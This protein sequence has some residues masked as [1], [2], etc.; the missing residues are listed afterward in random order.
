[1]TREDL[2][3]TLGDMGPAIVSD[4]VVLDTPCVCGPLL[5]LS[6]EEQM[7][8]RH[9]QASH[10]VLGDCSDAIRSHP[11]DKTVR[12]LPPF[13]DCHNETWLGPVDTVFPSGQRRIPTTHFSAR[14]AGESSPKRRVAAIRGTRNPQ[15]ANAFAPT[16]W[17]N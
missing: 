8:C 1:M 3:K 7:V 6:G 14:S 16:I 13:E 11:G 12:I 4:D 5:I 17:E 10:D 15:E 9:S 2:L